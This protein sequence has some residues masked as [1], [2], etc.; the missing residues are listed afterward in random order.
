MAGYWLHR[1]LAAWRWDERSCLA[2]LNFDGSHQFPPFTVASPKPRG[3]QSTVASTCSPPSGHSN[4]AFLRV[5]FFPL[6]SE[7]REHPV[8]RH[9]L[10]TLSKPPGQV[11][12]TSV[13][14]GRAHIPAHTPTILTRTVFVVFLTSHK[15]M[16]R[17]YNKLGHDH[18]LSHPY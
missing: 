13:S 18:F 6:L 10:C 16:P 15:Q 14:R 17:H 2:T 7:L 11:G 12:T 5:C 4:F 9:L 3:S 8:I 1:D